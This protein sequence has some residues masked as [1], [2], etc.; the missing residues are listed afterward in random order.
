MT[1][2][3]YVRLDEFLAEFEWTRVRHGGS[4]TEAARIFEAKPAT[5]KQ[6]LNRARRRG[7]EVSFTDDTKR[8]SA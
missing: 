3:P 6:R 7:I 1:R 4:V 2:Q 8:F 5:I